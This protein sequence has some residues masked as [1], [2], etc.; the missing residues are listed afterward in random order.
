MNSAQSEE[1]THASQHNRATVKDR[2]CFFTE[3]PDVS[4]P[5]ALPQEQNTSNPRLLNGRV[6]S[7]RQYETAN[8]RSSHWGAADGMSAP[9]AKAAGIGPF[10]RIGPM[11]RGNP[12]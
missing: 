1:L 12:S 8:H 6:A 3:W 5:E 9:A 11:N 2:D 7:L 4:H 10:G